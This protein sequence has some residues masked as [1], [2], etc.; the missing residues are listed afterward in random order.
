MVHSPASSLCSGLSSEPG[1]CL[2][3][4]DAAPLFFCWIRAS[5]FEMVQIPQMESLIPLARS[6]RKVLTLS[7]ISLPPKLSATQ[8]REKCPQIFHHEGPAANTA[9]APA[10]APARSLALQPGLW[11]SAGPLV[12]SEPLRTGS[13]APTRYCQG[14]GRCAR[15]GHA[16]AACGRWEVG[17]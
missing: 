5:S 9:A 15:N 7:A 2:P 6:C 1:Y 13:H 4:F 11:P 17:S 14:R 10:P 12:S 16:W 3:F 8:R